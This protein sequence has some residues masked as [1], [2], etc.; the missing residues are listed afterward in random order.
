[1]S[2]CSTHVSHAS[3]L[4]NL[5]G[6]VVFPC[7]EVQ[8]VLISYFGLFSLFLSRFSFLSLSYARLSIKHEIKALET[9]NSPILRKNHP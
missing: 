9:S 5:H 3:I 6:C 1:M 2:M 8:A 7:E 4:Q